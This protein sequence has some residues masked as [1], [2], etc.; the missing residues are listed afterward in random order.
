MRIPNKFYLALSALTTAKLVTST[1]VTQLPLKLDFDSDLPSHKPAHPRLLDPA[2]IQAL[3]APDADIGFDVVGL[4]KELDP[5]IAEELDEPRFIWVFDGSEDQD[6]NGVEGEGGRW[7][8]EGDKV[9]LRRQGKKFVDLTGREGRWSGDKSGSGSEEELKSKNQTWPSISHQPLVRSIFPHMT[10]HSMYDALKTFSGFYSRYYRSE[11]GRKSQEWLFR[12]IL[13]IV[14]N[15]PDGMLLSVE[16]IPHAYLQSSLIARFSPAQPRLPPSTPQQP[17]NTSEIPHAHPHTVVVGAH[18]DSA[19]YLFPLLPAPGADDDGSGSITILEAFRG[20][21]EMGF[22]PKDKV[23]EFHWYAAEEA[24]LLGS[25][26]VVDVMV[27]RNVTVDAMLEFDMT[28]FVKQ[29][30]NAT[31]NVISTEADP[32]LSD[33][34][35]NVAEEYCDIPVKRSELFKGAGSDYMSFS[36]AGFP[37][38]FATEADPMAGLF[39]PFV[40]TVADRMDLST[41]EFSFEHMLQFAKLTVGFVVE[42][43]GW[44]ED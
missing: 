4:L 21:V 31:I 7:M 29:G 30:S 24:G 36:R 1:P 22:K 6:G 18:Q 15:A 40:H 44:N 32:S 12:E 5:S 25:L 2:L 9:V 13:K 19:N 23:V 37:A 43:A 41:G 28:A 42:Q 14:A 17:R 8:T 10:T 38:A 16:T 33:W 27:G 35:I 11:D 20:L 3:T 26:D 39:D 34:I